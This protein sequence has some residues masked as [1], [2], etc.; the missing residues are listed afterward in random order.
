MSRTLKV[1]IS[2]T[3]QD[4]IKEREAVE[5]A[6]QRLQETV[7]VDMKYFGS[8][9]ETPLETCMAEVAHA[10]I[11][12]GIFAH[13]YGFIPEGYDQS[14]TELE[15]RKAIELNK[16]VLIYFSAI[17]ED[18]TPYKHVEKDPDSR[19]KLSRLKDH[20]QHRHTASAFN[21][22]HELATMVITDIQNQNLLE[23]PAPVIESPYGLLR[24]YLEAVRNEHRWLRILALER[25]IE[26]NALYI[27]LQLSQRF[28]SHQLETALQPSKEERACKDKESFKWH[29]LDIQQAL[30]QFTRVVIIGDP[31][32]GKTTSLRHL[33]YVHACQNLE[34]LKAN[35]E[36]DEVPIYI[37]LGIHGAADKSLSD[38]IWDV[39]RAYML[40]LSLAENLE[41]HL[42][43]GRALLLVLTLR[44]PLL[45][46]ISRILLI[47]MSAEDTPV[48]ISITN[49]IL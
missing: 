30:D 23:I 43:A 42:R 28:R 41:Q 25:E 16:P 45:E 4:L 6:L 13:R 35:Q 2:S 19:E 18:E 47:V 39:V 46:P 26:M 48:L 17:P 15:Y 8:R 29:D 34:R 3:Y 44:E 40:P 21:N 11:Y 27:R 14:M 36:P 37:P 1:F 38:Y 12:V 20:L 22:P 33:A 7:P 10:D 49:L 5:K 31:G 24:M 9:P 32:C